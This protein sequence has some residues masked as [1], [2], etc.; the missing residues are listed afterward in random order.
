MELRQLEYFLAITDN[1]SF[2]RASLRISV[3]QPVLSRHI[4]ALEQELGVALYH[5]TGHGVVL[6]EAG[7]RLEQYARGILDTAKVAK[8]EL[9]TFGSEPSGRVL[10][11]M[12]PSVQAVLAAPLVTKFRRNFPHV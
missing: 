12:P 5:R 11:G 10:I 1:K 4:K 6:S 3:A 8:Q 7:K 2:S 9:A